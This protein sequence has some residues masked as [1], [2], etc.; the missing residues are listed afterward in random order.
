MSDQIDENLF[1]SLQEDGL[2]E[3]LLRGRRQICRLLQELANSHALI[4]VHLLPGG[5]SFLSTILTLSE[6]E[7]WLF[8]DASPNE[9]IHRRCLQAER[10]FCVTQL[11]KIRIQF[12]LHNSSDVPFEG[13]PTLT[14]PIP[15]EILRLQ[16]RDAFRL[17]V[18]LSHGL[19]CILPVQETGHG[20]RRSSH[21]EEIRKKS[22]E[23]PVI[24]LSAGGLSMEIPSSKTAPIVGDQINGCHLKLPDDLI[25][26]NLE[27]R[28]HG[29]RI[30]GN[31]KEV[32]R[33]G[34]SFVSLPI[35]AANQIQR[36]IYQVERELRAFEA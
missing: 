24:D 4:S 5:L 23:V 36:Y 19:K 34:C 29:R 28:N 33:L 10:L 16:R 22:F 20:H 6:D 35:Q 15:D 25:A 13:R 3:F 30:L 1:V 18:P 31:N 21:H 7:E 12:R 26:V 17:Q 2:E 9:T 11:N 14:A 27:V 32:L 8:L